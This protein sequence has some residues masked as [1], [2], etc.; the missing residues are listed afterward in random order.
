MTGW[1]EKVAERA[2]IGVP[3][4]DRILKKWGIRPDRAAA[5]VPTL[6]IKRIEF[7]GFKHGDEAQSFRFK[8]A[9][10]SSGVWALGS[11]TNFVGKSTIFEVTRWALRGEPKQPK[12]LSSEMRKGW[13]RSAEVD[14]E[15]DE[16]VYG[17]RMN[18][19]AGVPS[20]SLVR[21][22]GDQQEVVDTFASDAG[23]AASDGAFHDGRIRSRTRPFVQKNG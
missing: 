1:V 16:Q 6:R 12:G 10:L 7:A 8:W 5:T 2:G 15:L 14:F 20:G 13:L 4:T 21:L 3:G 9:D 18:V 19:A 11:Y 17:V 23:F 22:G